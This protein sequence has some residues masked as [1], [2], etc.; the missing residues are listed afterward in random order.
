MRSPKF[1]QCYS[2]GVSLLI[3]LSAKFLMQSVV[4]ASERRKSGAMSADEASDVP[5]SQVRRGGR[6]RTLVIQPASAQ[7]PPGDSAMRAAFQYLNGAHESPGAAAQ[8][9]GVERQLESGDSGAK[10]CHPSATTGSR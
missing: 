7:P 2:T 4:L 9:F 3:M 8:E 5:L 1:E 10:R 6:A